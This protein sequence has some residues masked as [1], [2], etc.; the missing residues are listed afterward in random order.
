MSKGEFL[1]PVA[2][3]LFDN[4]FISGYRISGPR[5]KTEE[6]DLDEEFQDNNKYSF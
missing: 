5:N 4:N 2:G 3:N 6:D 1:I